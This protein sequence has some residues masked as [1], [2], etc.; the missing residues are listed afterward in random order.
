MG[1]KLINVTGE[2]AKITYEGVLNQMKDIN[3]NDEVVLLINSCGGSVYHG[4]AIYDLL[5]LL[6][7]TITTV[8]V[9][10][11][12]SI[13][14]ILFSLGTKRYIAQNAEYM[15]HSAS[16]HVKEGLMNI[17]E[18]ESR[19]KSIRSDNQKIINA[20]SQSVGIKVGKGVLEAI[21]NS[22]KDFFFSADEAVEKGFAT[23]ILK[24][25][26]ILI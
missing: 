10:S 8:T 3:S 22:G 17:D 24:D 20:I 2:I 7:N 13:A 6:P 4:F 26:S 21:F 11:C 18:C 15:I 1:K 25:I 23:D 5:S 12:I 16:Y 14:T 19:Q 9:G